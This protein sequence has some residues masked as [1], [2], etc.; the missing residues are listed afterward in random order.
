M[1]NDM[2]WIVVMVLCFKV[3][4]TALGWSMAGLMI[5]AILASIM[6]RG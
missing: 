3:G 2:L 1:I 4:L 6:N 5:L